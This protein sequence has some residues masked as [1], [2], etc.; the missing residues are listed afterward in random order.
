LG[1]DFEA[2]QASG[3]L[4]VCWQPTTE[5]LLDGLGARLLR[6]VETHG[7]KRVLID[8]LGGMARTATS[9]VRLT[10]FFS[11]LMSELRTRG[12]TV[13]ATWEIR[14]LFG[15]EITS[16]APDLSSIV[17]N[18][19]LTRFVEH[20]SELKRLLSILKVRDSYY[21]P[22]LLELVIHGHGIDLRKAFKNAE[23]VLS[24]SASTISNP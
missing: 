18:V 21:D 9:T 6:Q 23:A 16:P 8:S 10:E 24:G 3:A 13:F 7:I 15:P 1:H 22:S 12:V 14:G 5:G 19:L 4:H 20:E 17:D 2:L 11:T